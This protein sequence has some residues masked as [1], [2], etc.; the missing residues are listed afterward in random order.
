MVSFLLGELLQSST[1][2]CGGAGS[3]SPLAP[4]SFS[5]QRQLLSFLPSSLGK[6]RLSRIDQRE[7]EL[8][9]SQESRHYGEE[10]LGRST[11]L[12]RWGGGRKEAHFWGMEPHHWVVG[13]LTFASSLGSVSP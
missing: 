6:P 12:L 3:A 7:P 2:R 1:V 4:S 8:W 13:S 5:N 10:L 11:E 9:V